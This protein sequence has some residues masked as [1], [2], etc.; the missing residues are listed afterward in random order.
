LKDFFNQNNPENFDF[1]KETF[2]ESMYVSK[3]DE[4]FSKRRQYSMDRENLMRSKKI[5]N[6]DVKKLQKFLENPAL[7][8]VKNIFKLRNNY[9]EKKENHIKTFYTTKSVGS[10]LIAKR[11]G[12]ETDVKKYENI[13]DNKYTQ[14]SKLKL[15]WRTIKW[16]LEYKPEVVDKLL[17]LNLNFMNDSKNYSDKLK[18][19]MKNGL[20]RQEFSKLLMSY[21]ITH[22]LDLINKLFWVFDED[23]DNELTYQ[24]IAFG[25][26]M[27]KNSPPEQK[28]KALFDLCDVDN[29]GSISK[30]EFLNLMR[31]NIIN[32][33]EKLSMKQVVDKI[34]SC[35]KLNTNGEIT[36][37][38][39]NLKKLILATN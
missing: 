34:F 11:I 4:K 31:K 24:E 22:D 17:N 39:K 33:D 35:V 21:K 6:Q 37:Y 30:Q 23:G 2:K 14:V 3:K 7:G 19:E 18:S 25:I 5:Q 13:I 32:N 8:S 12:N 20:K 1:E 26:E 28:L 16:I 38:Y 29:S 36:L 15:K 10:S 27:F 9:S